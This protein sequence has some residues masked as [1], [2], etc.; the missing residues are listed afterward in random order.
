MNQSRPTDAQDSCTV[1]P[2]RKVWAVRNCNLLK[3]DL[4]EKCHTEV[5]VDDF[6]ER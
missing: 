2:H 4:F 5:P 3:S 6:V 1:H